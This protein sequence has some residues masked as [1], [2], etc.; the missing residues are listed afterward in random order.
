MVVNF[1]FTWFALNFQLVLFCL[2]QVSFRLTAIDFFLINSL[3][4]YLDVKIA[5]K[6]KKLGTGVLTKVDFEKERRIRKKK[7]KRKKKKEEEKKRKEEMEKKKKEKLKEKR[8]Q[9][10]KKKEKKRKGLRPKKQFNTQQASQQQKN[11]QKNK[12]QQPTVQPTWPLYYQRIENKENRTQSPREGYDVQLLSS[13]NSVPYFDEDDPYSDSSRQKRVQ[14]MSPYFDNINEYH[15]LK[16][17][18]ED[19]SKIVVSIH[20]FVLSFSA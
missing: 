15:D 17:E 2:K 1:G 14:I 20:N 7:E 4:S 13:E 3:A 11:K 9:K 12:Q 6:S 18:Y 5:S 16:Q 19:D 10:E 8:R